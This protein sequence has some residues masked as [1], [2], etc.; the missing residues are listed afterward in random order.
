MNNTPNCRPPDATTGKTDH[1]RF[2]LLVAGLGWLLYGVDVGIIA[3]A[4][5][6]LEGTSSLNMGQLSIIVATVLLGSVSSTMF[7]DLLADSPLKMNSVPWAVSDLRQS[8]RFGIP[9]IRNP[10]ASIPPETNGIA[11]RNN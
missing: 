3:G 6:H 8:R 2:L 9:D 10:R 1:E 4:L 5:S 11:C 7:A